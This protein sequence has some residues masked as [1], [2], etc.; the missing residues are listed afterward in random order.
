M[1]SPE[2]PNW[3]SW[4]GRYEFYKPE[5]DTTVEW[6]IPIVPET[7]PIWTNAEDTYTP[8]VET[9]YGMSVANDTVTVTGDKITVARWREDF[10]NDFAARMD[11]VCKRV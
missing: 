1:N 7:R 10:Q 2:N 5:N 3:G 8:T 11:W 4:G 9:P 6:R